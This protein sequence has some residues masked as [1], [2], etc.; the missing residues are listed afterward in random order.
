MKIIFIIISIMWVYL[1]GLEIAGLDY[2]N[3]EQGKATGQGLMIMLAGIN[4]VFWLN[5][6]YI[7]NF[8]DAHKMIRFLFLGFH[9]VILFFG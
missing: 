6:A 2:V 9:C 8:L 7:E 5:V 4:A 3:V 1:M